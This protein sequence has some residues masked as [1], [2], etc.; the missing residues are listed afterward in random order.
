ME[1]HGSMR[2]HGLIHRGIPP[3]NS[4][5]NSMEQTPNVYRPVLRGKNKQDMQF[6]TTLEENKTFFTP[7]QFERAKVARD[8]YHAVG[9][10]SI[11]DFKAIIQTNAIRNNPVTIDDIKLA[12]QIFGPDIGT[13]K[14][15]TTRRKPMPVTSD[16]IEIPKELIEAQREVT[17]CMDAMKVNG[18]WFLTT[19]SR[20]IYYRTAQYV[21]SQ[22]MNCY[23]EALREIIR[24]YNRAGFQVRRIHCDNEF[25]N[26][27]DELVNDDELNIEINYANPQEHVP[28]AERNNRVLKERVRAVYHRI[29][30]DRLPRVMVIMMVTEAARKLNF[31][32][33]KYGVSKY[34]SPRMIMHQQNLDYEKHCKFSFGTYVQAHDEPQP[35]NTQQARTLDRIYLRPTANAQGGHECFHIPTN[36]TVIRRRVTPI[37]ITPSVIKEVETLAENQNMPK[38]LKIQNKS[39]HVLFD[40]T[41]LA[42][43]DFDEEE[44]D[45]DD[46]SEED[47]ENDE[48]DNDELD[49]DE[50]EDENFDDDEENGQ[51][52]NN[53]D[54]NQV[55][56][57]QNDHRNGNE[58]EPEE[59]E[60]DQNVMVTTG[61]DDNNGDIDNQQENENHDN[62]QEEEPQL[63][64]EIINNE[65][66]IEETDEVKEQ[67]EEINARPRRE[68]VPNRF[69]HDGNYVFGQGLID[70]AHAA[71]VEYSRVNGKILAMAMHQMMKKFSGI[72]T[73]GHSN[74]Q[75]FS[76]R[77][78]IKKF[79]ERG[80][81][82]AMKELRQ[83]HDRVVFEP[84]DKS[85][86]TIEEIRKAMES[87]I[88]LAEKRDGQIKGR[89]CANG[90]VQRTYIGKDEAASPT[91]ATEAILITGVVD[92]KEERDVM[93]ADVPNAFV[94]TEVDPDDGVILMK[95]RGAM[96]DYL[97]EIDYLRYRDYVTVE[98]NQKVLYVR[99]VKALYGMLKSSLLYYKKFRKDIEEI[100]FEVN[101]YD[102]C[103]AN[104]IVNGNSIRLCGMSTT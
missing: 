64:A 48:N 29:P 40:T 23:R 82:A 83:L 77:Q 30:F 57:T 16:Y 17:L 41:W 2:A 26:I 87:L 38:G 43:V 35:S 25:S 13:L 95:I 66:E 86:L 45:D 99:M 93:T 79:G 88:F 58:D 55:D 28:E 47:A 94:Q 34:Y 80:K 39:G 89:V 50:Y 59:N 81:Q 96:V 24:V 63:E 4:V 3:W 91:V 36:R 21:E 75:T 56:I 97:L 98:D 78:G 54:E 7:R 6:V 90:S 100:G 53:S 101:P 9:T 104:R 74:V 73:V 11:E 68:R 76:L 70:H 14:G 19:I 37:P 62:L 12:E 46:Y 69:L 102:P 44:F 72:T 52:D 32:P 92:A 61:N 85:K 65:S 10:P 60:D 42:G 51:D 27:M 8:L 33:A 22:T 67:T 1:F 15:K 18:M 20:N 71:K 84:V 103:V 49:R 5:E 31:F